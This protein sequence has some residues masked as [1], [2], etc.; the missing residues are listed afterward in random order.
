M[1]LTNSHR[2]KVTRKSEVSTTILDEL[3]KCFEVPSQVRSSIFLYRDLPFDS[4][5]DLNQKKLERKISLHALIF[6]QNISK[7]C[8]PLHHF[9]KC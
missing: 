8:V 9:F 5:Y 1:V 2:G 4:A 6:A 7:L 3:N